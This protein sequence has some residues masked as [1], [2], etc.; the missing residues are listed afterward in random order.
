VSWL[1]TGIV[2]EAALRTVPTWLHPVADAVRTLDV[3]NWTRF[4]PTD[5]EGTAAAVL[6][7]FGE[8]PDILLTER[9]ADL[10]AHGGQPAFPGGV[11]EP[12][13]AS[14][15]AAALREA[16]EETGVLPGGIQVF[17]QLPDLWLPVSNYAVRP[18]LAWWRDP[19]EV[20]VSAEVVSA[21]RVP[22]E[23]LVDPANRC[24]VQHPSGYIG[25]GFTVRG[26]LVWGFTGGL[27]SMVLESAGWAVPWDTSR[28]IPLGDAS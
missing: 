9:A 21:H 17:G 16:H 7:L 5:G 2:D 18:V 23:E 22:I 20:G 14:H 25:P 1:R 3:H 11:V 19:S 8:G 24:S 27:L 10:R 4:V 6:L 28:V 15:V 12:A 13:D 26:L